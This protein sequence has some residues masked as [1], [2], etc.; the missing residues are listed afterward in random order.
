VS[1]ACV[2]QHDQ[3][4]CG[5]AAL[6]TVAL[7]HGLPIAVQKMR[8]LAGTDRVGTNLLGLLKAAERLGF[9]ARGVK[10]P[11][12]E[13][14]G[15]A[16]P[17]IA[18]WVNDQGLGHFVVLHRVKKDAAIV[19]DP[20]KG[21]LT[22]PREEFCRHWTG[23]LLL[24]APRQLVASSAPRGPWA[25]FL[26]LLRPHAGL[27]GEAFACAL[28]LTVLGL[29]TS[30]FIQHLV[31]TVLVHAQWRLLNALAAGMLALL[32]FRT[33]FG[34]VRQYLLVHVSRKVDV[35]LI[36][37]YTRHVLA[38]PI[39][40]F[41]MRRVGE[42]LSRLSDAVKVRQAVSGTTLTAIVDA[43][44]VV[45]ALAVMFLYDARLAAVAA[46]AIPVFLL[47]AGAHHPATKRLARASMEDAGALQAHLVENVTG[48]DTLKAFGA[49]RRRCDETDDRLAGFVRSVF[50]LQLI[51]VSMGAIG[52]LVAGAAGVAILWV[53][54]H[55]VIDGALTIGELMFFNSLLALMLQP[56][57]RLATVNLQ[58]Q[59]A[60][61]AVDRL[62]EVLD[63]ETETLEG[64][65]KAAFAG[66][67]RELRFERVTF[68]YGCRAE[69]LRGVDLVVPAGRTVAIVGESGSG[70]STLLKLLARFYDPTAGR[71]TADGIDLR[72]F[73]LSSLRARIGLVAQDPFI[74]TGTVRD[75]IALG[76]PDATLDQV[77]AAARAA[78]L[79]E[80]VATLPQRFDTVIGERG[81]NLSG[82]QRQR[83]AIARALLVEPDVLV[84]DEATS[85][86][87][88]ETERAIQQ[89]L[90]SALR[91]RTVLLVAHRL[92]TVRE[93]DLICVLE[94]GAVSERG[95]HDEL[96]L[97]GGRYAALWRAQVADDAALALPEPADG[98]ETA[99]IFNEREL[100]LLRDELSQLTA[101]LEVESVA[102]A[103]APEDPIIILD[104]PQTEMFTSPKKRGGRDAR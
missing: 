29:G 24:L 99:S 86:L 28:L 70:K 32:V 81:A 10:G 8:E 41:E 45:V 65:R 59:D 2:R 80:F 87:D 91:G 104:E 22:I 71:I 57:E 82:G 63:L 58:I 40:F 78:G 35:A 39:R 76:R 9:S 73:T 75:N 101:D 20:A 94:N 42:I 34:A 55:R 19:A 97:R 79:E 56:L 4:D 26:G 85:H 54:G 68:Q 13:L 37:G 43:T 46:V 47:A 6:A 92:S 102:G 25:R 12:E 95:T 44:L 100:R 36:S 89:S 93:A 66:V 98:G 1:Y 52:M 72:D 67:R 88:T 90:R 16:L 84:F 38:Q 96:L 17:A 62:Y 60:L 30:F 61:V 31:D 53:G 14:G 74:F 23:Y 51:N 15:V 27:L 11:W 103:A 48:V 77:A 69:V 5:A 64:D 18:H 21:V 7:H 33:L 3:S 49:E 83:L 50:S